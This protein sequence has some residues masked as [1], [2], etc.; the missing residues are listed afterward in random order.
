MKLGEI[1]IETATEDR[2]RAREKRERER[3]REERERDRT[4]E[5]IEDSRFKYSSMQGTI[6]CGQRVVIFSDVIII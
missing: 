1:K 5:K 4:R 6:D 2:E 3:E